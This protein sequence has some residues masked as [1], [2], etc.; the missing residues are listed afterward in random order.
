MSLKERDCWSHGAKFEYKSPNADVMAWAISRK[1]GK[2]LS[3]LVS[4][5]IWSKIGA[6]SDAYYLLDPLGKEAAFGGL[7]VTLRDL[8]RFGQMVLQKGRW[9]GHQVVPRSV[10]EDITKGG[11]RKAFADGNPGETRPVGPTEASGG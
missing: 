6:E 10:I 7:N 9:K 5:L 4:E 1:S 2:S 8:A 11:A 3:Q